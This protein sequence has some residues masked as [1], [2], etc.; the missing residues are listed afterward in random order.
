MTTDTHPD[1]LDV[2]I[3]G[4]G[5]AALE[6][7]M[8]LRSL[9]GERV[10]ITLLAPEREFRYRPMAVREPF[11][12]AHA[13]RVELAPIAAEF[14][15]Q[16][17]QGELEA[18]DAVQRRAITR[19]GE[20]IAYDALVVA[21]G[22]HGAPALDGAI[23]VDDRTL[24]DALRGLVQDVEEGY[25]TQVAF[26]APPQA[27][28]PL[29]LY[30]LALL[31]AHRAY[32]MNADVELAVVSPESAPLALFGEAVSRDVAR[33]LGKA[34]IAFHGSSTARLEHGELT[35]EP[36]G[37]RMR[38]GRVVALPLLEGPRIAGLPADAHGFIPVSELGAV[39]GVDGVYAAGDA[40]SYPIKH[41][42]IAA[43]QADVVAAAI[44]A[45]AGADVV[46]QPLRPVI[47][48]IL[49]TGDDARFLEAELPDDGEPRSTIGDVPAWDPPAKIVARHLGPYLAR[50]DRQTARA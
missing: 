19:A 13:Q 5:V 25:T 30:E 42:G 15:A 20:S 45:Q 17:V 37:L 26:V 6:A 43:Q 10:R 38:P 39:P 9:A 35:L 2:L 24:G 40:T 7:M 16:L 23:T 28:W 41:G 12:I 8:A 48:G 3:A 18:V 32:A 46:A 4:G 11:T 33:L 44:A 1:P 31:T 47:R 21:C 49:L 36:S 14:G 29:P 50:G 22:T 34:R 27:F